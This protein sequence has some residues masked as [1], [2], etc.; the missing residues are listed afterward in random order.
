[1]RQF[2]GWIGLCAVVSFREAPPAWFPRGRRPMQSHSVCMARRWVM[3]SDRSIRLAGEDALARELSARGA[4]TGTSA[5]WNPAGARRRKRWL[6]ESDVRS[7][8]PYAGQSP[9]RAA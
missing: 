4:R 8:L 5:G 9:L 2:N 6:A 7:E 1:M 3:A